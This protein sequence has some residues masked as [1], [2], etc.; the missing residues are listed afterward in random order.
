MGTA[1][2]D[3]CGK[4]VRVPD[5]WAVDWAYCAR[6]NPP[7][8]PR[9]A[10]PEQTLMDADTAEPIGPATDEQISAS[11]AAGETGIIL[12]GADGSVVVDG[13]WDAQ[14]PG[15]RRVCVA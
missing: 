15:V 9:Q 12:I 7:G 8:Y 14:Q 3:D 2:C 4:P 10:G 11:M 5:D 1:P 6:C 13:S